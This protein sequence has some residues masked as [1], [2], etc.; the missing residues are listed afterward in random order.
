MEPIPVVV[1]REAGIHPGHVTG[2]LNFFGLWVK[3][4]VAR[5]NLCRHR[6]NMHSTEKAGFKQRTFLWIFHAAYEWNTSFRKGCL[7]YCS[8]PLKIIFL[9]LLTCPFG[10]YR[11]YDT[12]HGINIQSLSWLRISVLFLWS[13]NDSLRKWGQKVRNDD[14]EIVES[15]LATFGVRVNIEDGSKG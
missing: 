15:L 10:A 7:F 5:E 9:T 8:T 6:E 12:Y 2:S 14:S 13:T 3:T 4:R 1:G 11:H